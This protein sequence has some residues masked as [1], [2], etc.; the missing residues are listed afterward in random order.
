MK[1]TASL[2][3]A[4]AIALFG[5]GAAQAQT[6]QQMNISLT[7]YAFAPDTLTLKTG[8][9]YRLH[10]T[11]DASKGHNFSAPAFFGAATIASQDQAKVK[12]GAVEVDEGQSVDVTVTPIKPGTYPLTCT[13]F[14]HE[15]FGMKGQIVVQ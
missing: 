15:T 14:L 2:F 5:I 7:S 3:A 12:D 8:T 10:L 13:H 4:A 1:T 6:A 9:A 11:N